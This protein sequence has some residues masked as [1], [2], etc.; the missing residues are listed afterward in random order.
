MRTPVGE[1]VEKGA[2]VGKEPHAPIGAF[3]KDG[4]GEVER[5]SGVA[6]VI[7]G[8]YEEIECFSGHFGR[9]PGIYFS[10]ESSI[11]SDVVL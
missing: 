1:P 8:G 9:T 11:P 2:V 7:D 6:E 3:E 5:E 4:F 10:S